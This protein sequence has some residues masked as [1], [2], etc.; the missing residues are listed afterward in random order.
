LIALDVPEEAVAM[1]GE[2]GRGR[3]AV[4]LAFG[5]NLGQNG[6]GMMA[7]A[8]AA[9][10]DPVFSEFNQLL[11]TPVLNESALEHKM[12]VSFGV[13]FRRYL[14]GGLS[15]DAGLMYTYMRSE[16]SLSGTLNDY[17][18]RQTLQYLGLPVSLSLDVARGKHLRWYVSGGG[19]AEVALSARA[20][21][22]MLS[23]GSV[24][25][26]ET[27][28][29]KA[30]GVAWSLNGSVG[31]EY[32]IARDMGVFL[33]PGLSYYPDNHKQP[34]SYRTE[35]PLNFNFRLGLRKEF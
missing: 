33:E 6:Q 5:P 13:M 11:E 19:M 1:D 27:V 8:G 3:S 35:H 23:S 24:I 29:L 2:R 9:M 10:R 34:S 17:T 20:K 26:D 7:G 18:Y 25:S 32:G 22:Q 21:V 28:H 31:L 15:L 16:S 14:T 4:S 30:K 12:P